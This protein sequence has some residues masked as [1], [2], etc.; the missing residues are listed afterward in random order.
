MLAATHMMAGTAIYRLAEGKPWHL[1]WPA[2]IAG[3]F[4]SHYILDSVASYHRLPGGSWITVGLVAVQVAAVWALWYTSAVRAKRTWQIVVP[5][6]LLAGLWAWLSW[7]WERI[8]GWNHLHLDSC[9]TWAPRYFSECSA[10]P[11]TALWEVGLVAG[12]A[13]LLWDRRA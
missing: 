6:E 5:P 10:N 1:R 4:A 3:G 12:M 11:W 7:D 9:Q 8:V 2:V 13:I